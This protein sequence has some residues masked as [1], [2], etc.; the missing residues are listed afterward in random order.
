MFTVTMGSTVDAGK[1][2]FGSIDVV[3][4]FTVVVG[5]GRVAWEN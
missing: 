2:A 1:V 5:V 3:I 4:G